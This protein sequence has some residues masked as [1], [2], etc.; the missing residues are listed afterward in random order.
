MALLTSTSLVS[1]IRGLQNRVVRRVWM[2]AVLRRV[3]TIH[4]EIVEVSS[5][6]PTDAVHLLGLVGG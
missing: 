3:T 6:N 4:H 5:S 1:D 2:M